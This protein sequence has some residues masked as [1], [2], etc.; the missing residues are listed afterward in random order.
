MYFVV[1]KHAVSF[2]PEKKKNVKPLFH[3]FS[4]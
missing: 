2:D 4:I 1:G 3:V